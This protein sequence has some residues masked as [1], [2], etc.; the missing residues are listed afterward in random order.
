MPLESLRYERPAIY[1]DTPRR[2]VRFAR[3][4]HSPGTL[5]P[6]GVAIVLTCSLSLGL[7]RFMVP[8]PAADMP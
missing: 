7:F 1:R 4:G 5:A 6:F 8:R 3:N 2:G